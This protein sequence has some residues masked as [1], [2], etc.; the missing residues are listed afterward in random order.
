MLDLIVINANVRTMEA[1]SG[2]T[3]LSLTAVAIKGSRIV[4]VGQ[5][6]D[7]LASASK[8]TRVIDAKGKVLLP[9]FNDSHVHFLDGGFSLS[10]VSLRDAKSPEE[11]AE[12][13]RRHAATVAAGKWITG[14][15]WDHE[16]WAGAPLPARRMIDS[17]TPNH[18]VMVSRLDGHMALA[19]SAALKLAGITRDTKDVP[20]GFIVRDSAGEPTGLLKDAAMN[21]VFRV[22]PS[23]GS[24]EKRAAAR[25]ATEYAARLGVTSVHDMLAGDDVKIYQSMAERGELKTRIYAMYP[26][27]K[28]QEVPPPYFGPNPHLPMV[29][30]GA[31]KGFSDGS[32]GSSTAW[33]F[34]PYADDPANRGLPG[35]LMFDSAM[36]QK[37]LAA[38]DAGLQISLHAIGDRANHEVLE[39][40]AKVAQTDPARDRRFRIEHAQHLRPSDIPRFRQ[41]RV[42]AS[43]QPYHA[44]DDGRWCEPRLGPERLAGT[45]A[46][47][48]LIDSGVVL[49]LGTDWT[50]A[51]LDPMLTISAAATRRTLD[52]KHPEGWLPGQKMTVADAVH[53][54]T[55]G[56]A[57]AEFAEEDKGTITAGKAADMIL[58]DTNIFR[59]KPEEI[60]K[61]RVVMTMLDGK[62]VWAADGFES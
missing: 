22:M 58:L 51:P 37:V 12:R 38:D 41:L 35:D 39:M 57:I 34:E 49:S 25:L 54:Y 50:V 6:K 62:I 56:S 33:F 18:P 9:G 53:A 1:P 46:F 44:V 43:V 52:G 42:V 5:T 32:L 24:E 27:A 15:E 14:G 20:G 40:F 8:K 30:T 31:V 59:I 3:Q 2:D 28:W 29:R 61:A 26:I 55:M 45:Y 4:E 23:V 17:V 21:A 10:N 47:R 19:N 36:L 11:F 60:P 13:I 16:N 48:S 7:I